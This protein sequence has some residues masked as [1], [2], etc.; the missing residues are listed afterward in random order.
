M[1]E[2]NE[3]NLCPPKA[4]NIRSVRCGNEASDALERD[5][6]TLETGM[7]RISHVE[8]NG[9]ERLFPLFYTGKDLMREIR[10]LIEKDPG[11]AAPAFPF[12]SDVEMSDGTVYHPD[13][14]ALTKLLQDT[15]EREAQQTMRSQ[16]MG[17]IIQTGPDRLQDKP[18]QHYIPA[19]PV[20]P[21]LAD[22]EPEP[23]VIPPPM[24]VVQSPPEK[25]VNRIRRFF[26]NR[27]NKASRGDAVPGPEDVWNCACGKKGLT[28]DFC[29]NCGAK[30]PGSWICPLCGSENTAKFC[31]GCGMKRPET[32]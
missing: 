11:C 5:I 4:L 13:R 10:A 3:Q 17:F 26:N 30:K 29:Y 24:G 28:S 31:N 7:L 18:P 1:A 23:P 25:P 15:C 32:E 27:F 8:G 12:V 2:T 9:Y 19:P 16:P 6:Y 14:E 22:D 20:V 21:P